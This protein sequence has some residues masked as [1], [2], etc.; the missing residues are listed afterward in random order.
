[1]RVQPHADPYRSDR[2]VDRWSLRALTLTAG[3]EAPLMPQIVIPN[4]I[5]PSGWRLPIG[6]DR[7][8]DPDA[9]RRTIAE[10]S[11]P[12]FD[13]GKVDLGKVDLAK[14]DVSKLDLGKVDLDKLGVSRLDLSK[15]DLP[16]REELLKQIGK[17]S[18]DRWRRAS[19]EIDRALPRRRPSATPFIAV[20]VAGGALVGWVLATT[21]ATRSWLERAAYRLRQ[22]ASERMA[23]ID[24]IGGQEM[25]IALNGFQKAADTYA[26][27]IGSEREGVATE[28]G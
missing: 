17:A 23:G 11:L 14:V 27:A 5:Q 13:L 24:E 16:A 6:R 21:P 10:L 22:W 1:M 8:R 15:L 20:G 9:R 25:D 18:K 28:A 19:K 2:D 3:E 26:A 7:Q 4:F 12:K